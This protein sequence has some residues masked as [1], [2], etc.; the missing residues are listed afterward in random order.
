MRFTQGFRNNGWFRFP[1][2]LDGL[3]ND[4]RS[5]M[6]CSPALDSPRR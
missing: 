3:G 6:P 4:F 2:I 5:R 1:I